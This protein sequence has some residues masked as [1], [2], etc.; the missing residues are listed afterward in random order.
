MSRL[1]ARNAAFLS[2]LAGLNAP[3]TLSRS[4]NPEGPELLPPAASQM[5]VVC[6]I[7]KSRC[8]LHTG[9]R[10]RKQRAALFQRVSLHYLSLCADTQKKENSRTGRNSSFCFMC[11]EWN[12]GRRRDDSGLLFIRSSLIFRPLSKVKVSPASSV[13]LIVIRRPKI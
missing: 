1:A 5:S 12:V 2:R 7:Q 11:L 8:D 3:K 10:Q 13:D 4:G 9:G 6:N